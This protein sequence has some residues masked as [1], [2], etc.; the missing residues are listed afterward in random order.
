MG[1]A[2]ELIITRQAEKDLAGLPAKVRSGILQ[3]MIVIA[4]DPFAPHPNVRPMVG[5][6]DTFRL[7]KGDWRAIYVVSREAITVT[8]VQA[9]HRREIYR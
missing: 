8:L 1:A 4:A 3:S 6:A 5:H 9:G 7:R 2:L